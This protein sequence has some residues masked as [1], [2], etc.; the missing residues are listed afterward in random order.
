MIKFKS[1]KKQQLEEYKEKLRNQARSYS[2]DI[3]NVKYDEIISKF[4]KQKIVTGKTKELADEL[5]ILQDEV[6]NR[7]ETMRLE[8]RALDQQYNRSIITKEDFDMDY[9]KQVKDDVFKLE[10][11]SKALEERVSAISN[12]FF[13]RK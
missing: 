6:N 10:S 7:L 5:R 12:N 13:I 2:I 1:N 4:N 9:Y 11:L 3:L 8:G